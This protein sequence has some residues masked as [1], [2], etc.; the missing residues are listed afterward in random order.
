VRLHQPITVFTLAFEPLIIRI[1]QQNAFGKRLLPE[2]P[3]VKSHFNLCCFI[4]HLL[5]NL[6]FIMR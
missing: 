4:C 1:P 2:I 5:K 3:K 6:N